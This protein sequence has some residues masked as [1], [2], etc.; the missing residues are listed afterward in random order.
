MYEAGYDL[1]CFMLVDWLN[2][3][4]QTVSS[5]SV[6]FISLLTGIPHVV[7]ITNMTHHLLA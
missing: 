7:D 6:P 1:V 3:G 5:G 2:L 4:V